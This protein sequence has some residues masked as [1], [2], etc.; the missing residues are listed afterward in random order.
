MRGEHAGPVQARFADRTKAGA[1]LGDELAGREL[2]D[3]VV[4]GLARGGVVVAAAVARRLGADLDVLVVRKLGHPH[5]PEVGLGAL[6]EDGEPVYDE[7]GLAAA[8]LMRSD[9]ADTVASERAECRRR[10]AAYRGDQEPVDVSGRTVVLVDD[11]VATGVTARAALL[12]L[13][14]RDVAWLVLATPVAASGA[15]A[16]L[17]QHTDD[18]VALLMP[19]DLVAVSR[20]Y[21]RFD[22]TEDDEVVRL[23]R[24]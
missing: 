1:A 5:A 8:G 24:A 17:D 9:L 18:V 6:A 3:P 15:L 20:W 14:A 23:L 4:L 21:E 22:Q 12:S 16:Q 10:K 2:T 19:P 7:I 13:R 11:G